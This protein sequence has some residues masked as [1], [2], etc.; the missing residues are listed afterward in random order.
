MLQGGLGVADY[1][2]CVSDI[3]GLGGQCGPGVF[4][5]STYF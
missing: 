4:H 5:R 3:N 1:G 2:L